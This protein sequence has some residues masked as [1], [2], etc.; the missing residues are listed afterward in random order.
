MRLLFSIVLLF[1]LAIPAI[2]KEPIRTFSCMVEQITD[3]DTIKCAV[4]K[5]GGTSVKVRLYGIDAPET[6]HVG[7]SGR[8][9]KKGQPYGKESADA[10]ASK[11]PTGTIL[12]VDVL[13]I[14]RYKRLVGLLKFSGRD[15]NREMVADGW[16]WAYRQYL[17]RPHASEY[18]KAEE[19]ARAKRL[20]LW[21]ESNPTPPWEFRKMKR[22]AE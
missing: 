2:A 6:E 11:I 9:F 21:K 3:G 22:S 13:A 16:A 14:D 7:K 10:L 20:G 19:V 18:L 1:A 8:I 15:I 4:K 12:E 17:D 5:S